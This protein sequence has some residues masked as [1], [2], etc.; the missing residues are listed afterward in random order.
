MADLTYV[1]I[2]GHKT[3]STGKIGAAGFPELRH[4]P[5][6]RA[7]AD[8]ISARADAEQAKRAAD[9]PT[10]ES[11]VRA[12]CNAFIRLKELG[13]REIMYL[14]DEKLGT[15]RLIE[16]GSSGIHEGHYSGEWPN[17]NW[18]IHEN[19]DLWPSRPC[20]GKSKEDPNG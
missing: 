1:E 13:W 16:P 15:I 4:D 6:T 10:E 18:W 3:V 5:L 19:G 11:A 14:S 7:E 9:M 2:V 17:G 8:E 12:M 20:L